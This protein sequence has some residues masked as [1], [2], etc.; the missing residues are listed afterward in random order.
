MLIKV[1]LN[2]QGFTIPANRARVF[3]MPKWRKAI[4]LLVGL[5]FGFTILFWEPI[6]KF[7]F[8][9][10]GLSLAAS[11]VCVINQTGENL[12]GDISVEGGAK[13]VTLLLPEEKACAA[14]PEA[15]R[16]ALI[17]FSMSENGSPYCEYETKAGQTVILKQFSPPINCRW[18]E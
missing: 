10:E 9:P 13:A 6:S 8:D 16:A 3:Y 7:L 5:V 18:F 17:K 1:D 15:G 4:V 14:S 11:H 12:V 2:K